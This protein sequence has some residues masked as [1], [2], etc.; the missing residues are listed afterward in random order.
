MASSTGLRVLGLP[1]KVVDGETMPP[2]SAPAMAHPR[3]PHRDQARRD[4]RPDR[5]DRVQPGRRLVAAGQR[6]P[7]REFVDLRRGR[8]HDGPGHRSGRLRGVRLGQ[9]GPPERREHH[10]EGREPASVHR[11]RPGR[12]GRHIVRCA[13]RC[14]SRRS[15]SARRGP[16]RCRSRRPPPRW[17]STSSSTAFEAPRERVLDGSRRPDNALHSRGG[18]DPAASRCVRSETPSSHVAPAESGS[19]PPTRPRPPP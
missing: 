5:G 8:R 13:P 11:D 12:P 17:S 10:A 9:A 15:A 2:C 1:L 4:P 19:T 3:R 6:Q 16:R 14:R 18:R 7:P